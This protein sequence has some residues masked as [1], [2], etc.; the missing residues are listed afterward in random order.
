MRTECVF[1]L[2]YSFPPSPN[3]ILH[4]VGS[5]WLYTYNIL[6]I[7]LWLKGSLSLKLYTIQ[8]N[9]YKQRVQ[10]GHVI[11]GKALKLYLYVTI[12]VQK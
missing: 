1:L 7:L 4:L 10:L 8:L 5:A 3:C 12:V 11:L 6:V 9:S 2:C